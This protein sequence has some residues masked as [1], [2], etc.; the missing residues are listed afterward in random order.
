MTANMVLSNTA[1]MGGGL[2]LEYNDSKLTA[3]NISFN[4]ATLVN[5]EG[6]GVFLD[7]SDPL[8]N[9]NIITHNYADW[10]GGLGVYRSSPD[11]YNNLVADNIAGE[12]GSGLIIMTTSSPRLWQTTIARNRGGDGTGIL[13]MFTNSSVSMTNTILISHTLGISVSL[14]NSANLAGTLWYSNTADWGGEGTIITGTHN[15]WGDPLFATDGYHIMTGSIAI[16]H[17][18][19]AGVVDDIDGEIR[20]GIPDLGADEM[21]GPRLFLPMIVRN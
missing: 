6:G 21:P 20:L 11:L 19:N 1:L 13:V 8:L 18:V 16:D 5:G 4:R 10:G 14:G 2:Y 9:R 12:Y 3:N 17:G 7:H 15:Y